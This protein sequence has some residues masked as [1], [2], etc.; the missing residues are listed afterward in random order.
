MVF[1]TLLENKLFTNF[2]KCTFAQQKNSYLGHIISNQG[3][4]TDPKKT[5]AML[6]W[7]IPQNFIELRGFI[8]LTGYY[9][10]FVKHYGILARPLTNILHHKSFHWS[11]EAQQAFDKLKIALTTTPILAFPDFTKTLI[12]ETDAC[13]IGISVVLSQD[14]HPIA[15]FNK[16]LSAANQKISTYEKDSLAMLMAVDKR[17]SFL[18]GN[19]FVIKIDHQSLCHLQDQTLSTN[20]QKK[21][22]R[23]LVDLQLKFAYK[24]GSENK[25]VDALSRVGLHFHLNATSVVLPIWIQEVVNSYHNDS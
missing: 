16:G 8:G 15:Y 23:K 11:K 18:H 21:A 1:Q 6:N 17:R 19:P 7:L 9:R 22:M 12:V 3:V 5:D 10:K 2:R 25:V 13:D 14:N 24:K 4:S 20:L